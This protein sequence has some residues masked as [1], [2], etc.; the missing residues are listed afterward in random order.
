[1]K[2]L[3]TN[4]LSCFIKGEKYLSLEKHLGWR[5]AGPVEK[6]RVLLGAGEWRNREHKSFHLCLEE[7]LLSLFEIYYQGRILSMDQFLLGG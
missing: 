3:G 1:M 6:K 5:A 4:Q 7:Y 2:I